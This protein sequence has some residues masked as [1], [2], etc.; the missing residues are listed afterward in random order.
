MTS[1]RYRKP[2]SALVCDAGGIC[3]DADG[4]RRHAQ[5]MLGL[6]LQPLEPSRCT[7]AD[8]HPAQPYHLHRPAVERRAA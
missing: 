2:T 4:V 1:L 5:A 7:Q 6:G 8:S 3:Y